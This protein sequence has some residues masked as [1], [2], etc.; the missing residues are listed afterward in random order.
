MKLRINGNSLRLRLN[1]AEV[2]Q[3]ADTGRVEEMVSFGSN[4]KPGLCYSIEKNATANLSASFENG[5]ITIFVPSEIADAWTGSEQVGF[6]NDDSLKILV[7]K[8]FACRKPRRG[9]DQAQNY[10]NPDLVDPC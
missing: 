7:E 6:E 5:K 3:F 10:P 2:G 9:E 8:D 4:G 1:K